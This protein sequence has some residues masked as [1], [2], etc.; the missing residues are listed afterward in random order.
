MCISGETASRSNNKGEKEELDCPTVA[1]IE[2]KKS[3]SQNG[4]AGR[5]KF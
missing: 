2:L 4:T 5:T 1:G 3:P